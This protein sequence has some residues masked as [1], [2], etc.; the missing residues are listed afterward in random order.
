MSLASIYHDS[1]EHTK[2]MIPKKQKQKALP[3]IVLDELAKRQATELDIALA[4][5]TIGAA[6]FACLSC[7][8]SIVPKMEE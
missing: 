4:Q 3:F 8:Y 2:T 6:F 5:L 1:I 7:E